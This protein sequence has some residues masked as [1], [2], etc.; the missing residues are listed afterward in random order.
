MEPAF[1]LAAGAVVLAQA[2]LSRSVLMKCAPELLLDDEV[3]LLVLPDDEELDDAEPPH[4][5][6]LQAPPPL[7]VDQLQ[8]WYRTGTPTMHWLFHIRLGSQAGRVTQPQTPPPELL[9][10]HPHAEVVVL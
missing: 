5:P 7:G 9:L 2:K 1:V 4:V 3:E 8:G 10:M 6:P